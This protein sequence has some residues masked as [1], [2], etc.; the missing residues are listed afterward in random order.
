MRESW[1][2]SK[3]IADGQGGQGVIYAVTVRYKIQFEYAKESAIL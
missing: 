1:T 2:C 3:A